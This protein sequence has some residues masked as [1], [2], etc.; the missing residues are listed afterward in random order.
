MCFNKNTAYLPTYTNSRDCVVGEGKALVVTDL[1]L[2][3]SSLGE[4]AAPILVHWDLPHH[5]LSC[6]SQ[7]CAVLRTALPNLFEDGDTSRGRCFFF[8]EKGDRVTLR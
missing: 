6:F 5:S 4:L 2:P 8:V 7:R 3:V 1:Y